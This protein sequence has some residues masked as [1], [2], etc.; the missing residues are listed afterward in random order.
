M[1]TVESV[2]VVILAIGFA[3]LLILAIVI[4]SLVVTVL[5]RINRISVKAEEATANISEAAA[6]V[7]SKIA[8]VA[9]S[10]IIGLVS[11]K[12]AKGRK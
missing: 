1:T 9:L 5:R 7:G 10:T 11:K 3:V 4:A 8:P 6:M 12:F 2:L